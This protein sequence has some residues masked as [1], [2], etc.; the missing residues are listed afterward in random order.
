MLI[1]GRR[2]SGGIC[3]SQEPPTGLPVLVILAAL[4]MC[5]F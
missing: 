5:V 1:H 2:G 3:C 4:A